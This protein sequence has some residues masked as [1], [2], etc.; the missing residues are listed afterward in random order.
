MLA[1]FNL[2]TQI[3]PLS[4]PL[5]QHLQDT[6]KTREFHKKEYLL[7]QGHICQN[8][9]FIGRGLVRCFYDKHGKDTCSWF[10]KENDV[11]ISVISFFDQIPSYENMQAL[12]DTLVHYISYSEL[13]F[14]YREYP[15]F[16]LH[17]RILTEKYYKLAELRSHELRRTSA[18][19]R[20]AY[21]AKNSPELIERIGKTDIAN[22]YGLTIE[23]LSRIK[24]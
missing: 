15:E 4:E 3:A 1:L 7:K 20:Y 10:M 18:L 24:I 19:E 11:V 17:G 8:I 16:N 2:F 6:I 21:M 22:Y 14:I 5:T 12:E 9:S 23:T 13:Q